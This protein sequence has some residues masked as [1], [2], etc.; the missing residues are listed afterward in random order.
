[1]CPAGPSHYVF[2]FRPYD[3]SAVHGPEQIN[4]DDD[5]EISITK[6]SQY[7]LDKYATRNNSFH[8]RMNLTVVFNLF[9]PTPHFSLLIN[10]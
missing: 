9:S 2:E 10:Q 4:A 5:D 3:C 1:M 7:Q 8:S 6:L